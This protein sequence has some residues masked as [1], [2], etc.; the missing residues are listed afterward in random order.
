MSKNNVVKQINTLEKMEI[1]QVPV[2]LILPNEYN[3][4]RQSDREFELLCRSIEED[5]FTQPIIV[6]KA[7]AEYQPNHIVDGEHRWRACKALGWETVPVVYVNFT[8]AQMKISTLRHNRARGNEDISMAADV[9]KDLQNLN[10]LDHA[11]ESLLLDDVELRIMLDDIDNNEIKLRTPGE[12]LTVQ[13]V[14]ELNRQEKEIRAEAEK[15]EHRV[16]LQEEKKLTLIFRVYSYEKASIMR[17]LAY[18][19]TDTAKA[20]V[21]ICRAYKDDPQAIAYLSSQ[22]EIFWDGEQY[23][24]KNG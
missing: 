23:V 21:K 6:Q 19:D 8:E 7:D 14:E 9:L 13:D 2:D 16:K 10:A 1:A 18:F 20:I 12:Q 24:F 5:G 11:Q 22:E 17:A 15:Q 3:P 4:N